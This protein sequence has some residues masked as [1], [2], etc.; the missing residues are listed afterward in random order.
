M[1]WLGEFN[2][3]QQIIS[4]L[5]HDQGRRKDINKYDQYNTDFDET[6]NWNF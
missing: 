2:A 4:T 3:F 5:Y 6:D 1:M